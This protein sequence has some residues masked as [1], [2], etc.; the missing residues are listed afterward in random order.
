MLSI[1]IRSTSLAA[2][3]GEVKVR[4][5]ELLVEFKSLCSMLPSGLLKDVG[6]TYIEYEG[7]SNSPFFLYA[8]MVKVL[9]AHPGSPDS[10]CIVE[11]TLDKEM[12]EN[13]NSPTPELS[14]VE[15]GAKTIELSQAVVCATPWPN[16]IEL[17]VLRVTKEA[18]AIPIVE[19]KNATEMP[20]NN[21]GDFFFG[22]SS[23][24]RM[25]IDSHVPFGHE[26]TTNRRNTSS[27]KSR[28]NCLTAGAIRQTP[29]RLN[30]G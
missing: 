21:A 19:I 4:V 7:E 3:S 1:V 10:S 22:G 27:K 24:F 17:S 2:I 5:I 9:K 25:L 8:L 14:K 12:L 29:K 13:L 30:G 6:L 11:S 26:G 16:S 20:I 23:K 28:A 15:Y 18:T